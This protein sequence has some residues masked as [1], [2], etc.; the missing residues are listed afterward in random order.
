M[1]E[2]VNQW[3][4]YMI[5]CN[6]GSLYVGMT[7][8]VVKRVKRHNDGAGAEFTSRH[9][10]VELVWSEICCDSDAARQR[11]KEIKGWSRERKEALIAGA[12]QIAAKSDASR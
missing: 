7:Q 10:P 3:F 5:R 2:A 9:R 8:D 12:L 4:C 11:E 1:A 6:G